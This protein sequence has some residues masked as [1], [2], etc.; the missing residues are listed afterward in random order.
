MRLIKRTA[1]LVAMLPALAMMQLAAAAPP[2]PKSGRIPVILDTDIGTDIDDTWALCLALKSPEFDLRLILCDYPKHP[3][4]QKTVYRAKII[5]KLL[6]AAGRTDIPVGLGAGKKEG[7]GKQ[8][9]EDWVRDYSLEDYPG[10]VHEDGVGAMIKTVMES[11]EPITVIATGPVSNL[12]VALE[13]E[14]RIATKARFVG[15]QG[16]IYVGYGGRGNPAAEFN[17][18]CNPQA[19]QAV[20][21]APWSVTITPLDTCGVVH[22]RGKKYAKIRDSEDPLIRA[23]ME[24][25]RI[26]SGRKN[27]KLPGGSSTLFDTVAIY[28]AATDANLCKMETL[29]LRVTDKGMTVIDKADGRKVRAA[30]K[31]KDLEAFEDWIVE[32]LLSPTVQP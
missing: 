4:Y 11:Q 20:F 19:L 2:G 24:N 6:E 29:P 10:T 18:K 31:W 14:P 22:V 5:A 7:R 30:V 1:F 9:Q 13:R 12:E 17:V 8:R 27:G 26:W 15:M 28:L 32:R 23:L 25:Y 21:A 16:S 3:E